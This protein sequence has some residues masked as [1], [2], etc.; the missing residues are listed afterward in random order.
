MHPLH[1]GDM[2]GLSPLPRT[3]NQ[4][5]MT[6]C[7]LLQLACAPNICWVK[8]CLFISHGPEWGDKGTARH[9]ERK[10]ETEGEQGHAHDC[11][12]CC[13]EESKETQQ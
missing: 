9:R 8:G 4:P 2:E 5:V 13:L 3:L 6:R 12:G 7:S 10:R 1:L 11:L